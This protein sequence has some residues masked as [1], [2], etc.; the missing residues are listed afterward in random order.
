MDD[1]S[2]GDYCCRNFTFRNSSWWVDVS[3]IFL[4]GQR[5]LEGWYSSISKVKAQFPNLLELTL[6]VA[7]WKLKISVIFFVDVNDRYRE[8]C[9]IT[10]KKSWFRS[11]QDSFQQCGML[12]SLC[13]NYLHKKLASSKFLLPLYASNCK[14]L[15][16]R[17]S[18]F[19]GPQ[20]IHDSFIEVLSLPLL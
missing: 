15:S 16:V 11:L 2:R 19:E 8:V 12:E 5:S 9:F 1:V 13:V 6:I 18:T 4:R 17:N 3:V 10:L 14:L 7:L 20:V